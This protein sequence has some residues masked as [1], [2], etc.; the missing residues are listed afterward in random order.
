MS[1]AADVVS[2]TQDLIRIDTSN[3][4]DDSGPGEREATEYVAAFLS[5]CGL[6]P[7]VRES[8]PRRTNLT[9]LWEGVDRSRPP[10]VVH[11]HLD[12]VPAFVEEWRHPPFA[13]EISDGLLWGRGAVDMKATDGMI[14]SVV[15]SMI[16]A[17]QKPSRD[18]VLGFFADEENGGG[19][20]AGYVVE[21]FPDDFYGATEAVSEV[22]GFSIH[23]GDTRAYLIQTAEKGIQWLRLL[24]TGTAGHGS[25]VHHDNAVTH[26]AEALAR[27]GRYAWP[28]SITPTVETLLRGV[29]ELTGETY[30]PEPE[31]VDRLVAHL[32]SAASLVAPTVR[33]TSN[34]TQLKA[35]YK[36][37]VIPNTAEAV[38][39]TRFVYGEQEEVL[40][41]IERLAGPHT[42][43]ESIV[44]DV[45]LELPFSGD[46]VDKMIEALHAED[47]D[48]P[49]L[50]YAC[51]GGTDNKHLSRIGIAGY[52]FAPLR[53]PPELNFAA[54]FHG[55]DERVPIDGLE[56]GVRV[57]ERFLLDC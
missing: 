30:A 9:A 21:N 7:T 19:R 57:F 18:I 13:A 54:L 26:L 11:G 47:P 39:D 45:A 42:K 17:G 38:V 31:V 49:V 35:G 43:V 4:G 53:L 16:R 41:T 14:L 27:I 10:L 40:A 46:L 29:A 12:V 20:G 28:L 15:S 5:D 25:L 23:I 48:A 36:S 51:F 56:F 44:T 1:A 24:A 8:A 52:G 3:Y 37:N 6:S 34:P 32:G 22:G 33:N 50:P 2:I 55:V